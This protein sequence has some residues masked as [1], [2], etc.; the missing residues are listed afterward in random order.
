MT[1][2]SQYTAMTT[3]AIGDLLDISED[4]GG[5]YGSRSITYANLLTNLNSG[6]AI[7]SLGAANRVPYINAGATDFAYSA[8]FT[9]DGTILTLESTM[10]VND[11]NEL[12]LGSNTANYNAIKSPAGMGSNLT[13]TMP[14]AYPTTTGQVLAA[15]TGGVMSW[16][17]N[18]EPVVKYANNLS[19]LTTAV[20]AFNT[21]G[22]GGIVKLGATITLAADLTIDFGSGIEVWGGGF[23]FNIATY[24]II[25][26]GT[27]GT[28]RN[29]AFTGTTQLNG[30]AV[31]NSQPC[32][33]VDDSSFVV[34][35]MIE[36]RFNDIIGSTTGAYTTAA[37]AP[38]HILDCGAWSIFEF[39]FFGVGS[40]TSSG[41]TKYQGPLYV[42]WAPSGKSGTRLVFKDFYNNSPEINSQATRFTR[43]RDSLTIRIDGSNSTS[44]MDQVVYDETLTIDSAST[45][46]N[47]DLYPNMYGSSTVITASD[48]TSVATYGVPGDI[49]VS[50][51]TIY[52]KHT[53]VGS[54]TNWK[55][56]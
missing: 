39:L 14:S 15:T 23:G 19:E 34:L 4:L 52:M 28:F 54:N 33:E 30:T 5:S 24:K 35:K 31:V 42:F 36:C 53:D 17:D 27:R 50:G 11:E 56:I 37:T 40:A 18:T 26:N 49:V 21:A 2:I 16:A 1:K 13:Y 43:Y 32:I 7:P 55:T 44:Y 48:P 20:A 10:L 8:D 41:S 46:P 22:V 12:R 9:Y 3:L 25:V 38:I 45:W 6:L 51:S 29:V 47:L